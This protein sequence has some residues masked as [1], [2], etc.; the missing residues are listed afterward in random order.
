MSDT[1]FLNWAKKSK[2]IETDTDIIQNKYY[3][4][5]FQMRKRCWVFI[6]TGQSSVNINKFLLQADSIA[7][8]AK[9]KVLVE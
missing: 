3:R 2:Q 5:A 6:I 9:M 4:H 1:M 8:P 7:D